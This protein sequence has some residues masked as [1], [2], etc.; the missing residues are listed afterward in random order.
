MNFKEDVV[1]GSEINEN[2]IGNQSKRDFCYIEREEWKTW[3]KI[4]HSKNEYHGSQSHHFLANLWGSNGKSDALFSRAPKSLQMVTA[5]MELK[6]TCFL[7][8]KL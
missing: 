4:Q 7:E 2:V 1:E 8:E 3:L 5:A 6:G